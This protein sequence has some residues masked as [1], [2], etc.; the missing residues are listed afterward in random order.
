MRDI[1]CN[2][3]GKSIPYGDQIE[4][5][6]TIKEYKDVS[7]FDGY[8]FENMPIDLCKEC[9]DKFCYDMKIFHSGLQMIDKKGN[10]L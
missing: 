10:I 4:I 3:C 1:K 5:R 2:L 8:S 6:G 9:Y 7:D